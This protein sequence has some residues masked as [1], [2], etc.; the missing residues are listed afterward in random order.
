[1]PPFGRTLRNAYRELRSNYD[2]PR[3]RRGRIRDRII[4]P[5]HEHIYPTYDGA[6]DV[7]AEDW[8]TLIVL[9]ACRADLFEAYADVSTFDSYRRVTSNASAT[10]EWAERTFSAGRFGDTVCVTANPFISKRAGDSFHDLIEV[11]RDS[12]DENE[13][14]VLPGDVAV[15]AKRA[16]REYPHKRIVVHFMQ[17]HYPFI[18]SDL[19]FEGWDPDGFADGSGRKTIHTPW[20][21]LQHGLVDLDSV[22]TAYGEN[23]AHALPAVTDLVATIEGR[24]VITSDHGNG[25]G[26]RAWPIPI[27]VYGHP[28]GIR[29]RGLTTVPWAVVENGSRRAITDGPIN[30]A[31]SVG[32]QAAERLAD[33]GYGE[34]IAR[35][36][37]THIVSASGFSTRPTRAGTNAFQE[38]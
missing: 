21:A 26:E 28:E 20:D 16:H 3:W 24:C 27:R 17:P 15:A 11:W 12:F 22:W 1:M 35:R 10:M 4:T 9:D 5:V 38:V 23:L 37:P 36:A 14:T 7:M 19:R 6:I 25:I 34:Y 18:G 30:A 31:G 32:E 13:R 33:L 8:D 29:T 2:D